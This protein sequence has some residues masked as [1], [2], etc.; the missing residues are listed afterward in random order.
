MLSRAGVAN[1]AGSVHRRG[2]A[3]F[4]AAH[5]LVGRPVAVPSTAA[6]ATSSGVHP[7]APAT[8]DATPDPSPR[9]VA[10]GPVSHVPE[11]IQRTPS[12]I[13]A[14]HAVC[15]WSWWRRGRAQKV[16]SKPHVIWA[17][18]QSRPKEQLLGVLR[19]G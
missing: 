7:L 14:T 5:G 3:V 17:N 18:R 4:L 9:A 13:S 15:T 10:T 8:V 1:E 6:P 2:V 19:A 16:P 11:V 12:R